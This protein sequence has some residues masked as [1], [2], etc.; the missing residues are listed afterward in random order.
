V[1]L[2]CRGTPDLIKR[3]V[4]SCIQEQ[5]VEF[6]GYTLFDPGAYPQPPLSVKIT[7]RILEP[8]TIPG[9]EK[10]RKAVQKMKNLM[11][12]LKKNKKNN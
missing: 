2:L 6:E 5:P 12:T 7:E 3:A 4:W 9:N 10:E 11:E 1:N 8:W